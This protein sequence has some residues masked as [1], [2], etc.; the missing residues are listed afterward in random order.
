M[1]LC[2]QS[3]P[4]GDVVPG[5]TSNRSRYMTK[6][7]LDAIKADLLIKSQ[8]RMVFN[9]RKEAMN[10][11]E[12]KFCGNILSDFKDKVLSPKQSE[13]AVQIIDKYEDF[14]PYHREP[15]LKP[16]EIRAKKIC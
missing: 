14:N 9:T 10:G 16:K 11:W 5:L 4:G 12:Q 2:I 3:S 15:E 8:L 7:S 6:K 1:F 13:K